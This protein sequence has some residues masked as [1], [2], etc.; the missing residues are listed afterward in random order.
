MYLLC[1]V[2]VSVCVCVCV[3]VLMF[4]YL[5]VGGGLIYSFF[6]PVDSMFILLS[7]SVHLGASCLC[8]CVGAS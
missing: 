8:L 3:C 4:V 7:Q 1:V 6:F 5:C 2:F